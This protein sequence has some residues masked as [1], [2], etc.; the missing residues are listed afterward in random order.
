MLGFHGCDRAAGEALL[1]N[2]SP[3][4]SNEDYDWLGP[5][6]YFWEANPVRGLQFAREKAKRKGGRLKEPFVVGA[7]LDLGRCLDLTTAASIAKLSIAFKILEEE[8]QASGRPLPQ[9]SSDPDSLRRFLDCAV[10]RRVHSIVEQS[11]ELAFD[12]V[13]GI[14]QEGRPAFPGSGILHKT[15]VQ[16]A[17]RNPNNIKGFFRVRPEFLTGAV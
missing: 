3:V 10:I 16:I 13:R 6:V 2:Q 15:H 17:V 9:N 14:F 12:T 1:N 8:H 7:I 11:G 5:G 4:P